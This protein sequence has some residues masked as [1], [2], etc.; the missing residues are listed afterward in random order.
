MNAE[1]LKEFRKRY[2]LSQDDVAE[3]TGV[4]LRTVR[5]WEY[6]ERLLPHRKTKALWV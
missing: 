1:D 2:K 3:I 4:G 6:G 5:S